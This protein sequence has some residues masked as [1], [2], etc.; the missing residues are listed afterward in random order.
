MWVEE[1]VLRKTWPIEVFKGLSRL[2][3]KKFNGKKKRRG[4]G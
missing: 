4:G 3:R 2:T 1:G